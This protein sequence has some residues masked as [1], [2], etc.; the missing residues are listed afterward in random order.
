MKLELLNYNSMAPN[1]YKLR[2]ER[3]PALE[4]V[5]PVSK[6]LLDEWQ[7]GPALSGLTII[8]EEY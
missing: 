4:G 8:S 2:N 1:K 5:V 3:N 6:K 7:S